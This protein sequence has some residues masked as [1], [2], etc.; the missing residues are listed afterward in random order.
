M[1][2]IMGAGRKRTRK[3]KKLTNK[4]NHEMK[5]A[6]DEISKVMGFDPGMPN[7]QAQNNEFGGVFV[8]DSHMSEMLPEQLLATGI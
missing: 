2:L 3:N 8:D 6:L 4:K 1:S 7:Q 5:N